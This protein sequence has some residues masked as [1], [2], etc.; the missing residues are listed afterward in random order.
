[1]VTETDLDLSDGRTLH[2]YDTGADDPG[3]G[4]AVFWL[5]GTPNTGEPPEPLFAA[6]AREGIRWVFTAADQAA[7][8]GEWAWLGHVAGQA[9]DAG[10]AGLIDDQLAYVAPWG[11]DPAQVTP[12]V[13]ILH[14]GQDRIVP[15]SH[16]QWLARRCPSAEL[17]LS[18]ADG[19]VSVLS[20]G[21]GALAWLRERAG[22]GG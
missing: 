9:V 6:A 2:V 22:G 20:A 21:A 16:S 1:V 5:H 13:L 19:H 3:S 12:P 14:G 4:L 8:A 7:L 11:F 17:R 10:P 18:P 15:S